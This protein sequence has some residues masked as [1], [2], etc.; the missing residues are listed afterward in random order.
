MAGGGGGGGLQE[1]KCRSV[2]RWR[3]RRRQRR[4]RRRL[5][6]IES[7][8]LVAPEAEAA[9]RT[10]ATAATVADLAAIPAGLVVAEAA[11]Q[12]DDAVQPYADGHCLRGPV[13]VISAAEWRPLVREAEAEAE[14]A[15]DGLLQATRAAQPFAGFPGSDATDGDWRWRRCRARWRKWRRCHWSRRQLERYWCAQAHTDNIRTISRA[16]SLGDRVRCS[17]C[18]RRWRSRRRR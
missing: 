2:Y 9:V 16:A 5:P 10:A 17:R 3:W 1:S 4:D 8:F 12:A 13:H 11:K 6:F 18:W 15:L 7:I 14:A